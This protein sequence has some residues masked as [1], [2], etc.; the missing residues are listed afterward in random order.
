MTYIF[1]NKVNIKDGYEL[2]TFGDLRTSNKRLLGEYRYMYSQGASTLMNDLLVGSGTL[3]TDYTRNC[4]V[5]NT[6]QS[7]GDRVV[8]QTKQYHPYVTGTNNSAIISFKFDTAKANLKQMVGMFDDNNGFFL[9][10]NGLVPELVIRKNGIDTDVVSQ[11]NWNIDHFDGSKDLH[12]PSGVLVDWTKMQLIG[13]DYYWMN[14]GRVRIG[15]YIQDALYYAH[16]FSYSNLLTESYITQPSLPLRWELYNNGVVSSNS[17]MIISSGSVYRE[18]SDTV[19][20]GFTRAISTNANTVTIS[21]AVDGTCILALRLKNSIVGK[22]VQALARIRNWTLSSDND[23]HFKLA[24]LNDRTKFINNGSAVTWTSVSGYGWC[25]YATN[26]AMASNW[27]ANND[28]Q[29]IDDA[30]SISSAGSGN[31]TVA[32][33]GSVFNSENTNDAIYQNYNSTDSQIFALIG[34][35]LAG[36]NAN[37]RASFDFFEVK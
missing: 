24:I 5:A 13:I 12:N 15:F 18:N 10:M 8:R 3:T 21:N 37:V 31:K 14:I 1:N 7:N 34:Y 33:S 35:Q 32:S 25:E 22:P 36:T 16:S 27:S 23:I 26:I 29:I 2:N 20:S 4:Y 6:N 9:R 28:Y 11:S 19:E 17:Q 30:F